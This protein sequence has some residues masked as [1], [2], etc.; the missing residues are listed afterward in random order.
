[1][2]IRN[3]NWYN[4]N[5][6]RDYPLAD[7]ASAIDDK[8]NRLPQGII[9]DIRVRWP[10]WAGEYAFLGSVAV[11][12]GAV[13]ATVLCATSL[14]NAGESYIPI[15][16]ASVP[17]SDLE[18]GRQYAME[19]MYPGSF[20]YI[21]FGSGVVNNFSGR[22]SSP[23]QSLLA[24]RAAR[25]HAGLP[26]TGLSKLYA[27]ETLTG[28]VHF[29]AEE[30]LQI[31]KATRKIYGNDE[32]VILFSLTT[33]SDAIADA[34]LTE[35]MLQALAGPCGAR[36]ESNTCGT[37]PP[38]E[39]INAVAP[40][41]DGTITIEFKGCAL[42]GRNKDDGS[43]IIDCGMGVND[44]C[45]APFIPD[46]DGFLPSEKIPIIPT[47]PVP[48]EPPPGDESI[49]EAY[50]PPSFPLPHCT[51][52]DDQA[53][54]PDFSIAGG[55]WNFEADHSPSD[56]CSNDSESG[57]DVTNYCIATHSWYGR[58]YRDLLI[59]TLDDQTVY[60]KYQTDLK[61]L[62]YNPDIP[63]QTYNSRNGGILVNYRVL[64][65]GAKT[66]WFATMDTT[67]SLGRFSL[68]YF[69]GVSE[70]ELVGQDYALLNDV[71]YRI[72]LEVD[73]EAPNPGNLNMLLT[74]KLEGITDP[75]I[76]ITLGP[77][78]IPVSDYIG[79][80]GDSGTAGLHVN[81]AAT[82]FSYWRVDTNA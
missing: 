4:L 41:C 19:S 69:N 38:I 56:P 51:S 2:A 72:T 58:T 57:A 7:T 32:E 67:S 37:P 20:G 1:M 35:S 59:F 43:I 34:G 60:R 66:F 76:S 12:S 42:I 53:Y 29:A 18:Q 16:V 47:P 28:L 64:A 80:L 65:N 44:T 46:D 5:E 14:A 27:S 26:V 62:S 31:T 30:P 17:L 15:A 70:I 48:P 82:R 10:D 77:Y 52:F 50:Q 8:E 49:S 40:D 73:Q 79:S 54:S 13:T 55:G 36:P 24:S 21:T 22:F 74:A 68:K 61:L 45:E 33:E 39:Y 25:P 81:E 23:T 71:W 11:T 63:A 78:G 6:S 3:Q 75:S 9:T